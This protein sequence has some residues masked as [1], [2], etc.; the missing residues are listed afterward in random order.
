[1]NSWL[2]RSVFRF[3]DPPSSGSE[4]TRRVPPVKPAKGLRPLIS[5]RNPLA[6]CQSLLPRVAR[7]GPLCGRTQRVRNSRSGPHSGPTAAGVLGLPTAEGFRHSYAAITREEADVAT[8][9]ITVSALLA[10]MVGSVGA[11]DGRAL[12]QAVAKNIGADN[13][14]TLQISGTGWNAAPGQSFS[15]SDDWPKFEVTSY[16]KAIDFGARFSRE[17]VTRRQGNYPPRGGGGTPI[18]RSEEH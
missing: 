6:G 9:L 17:Q 1:M 3:I 18:Q 2:R 4:Y 15:P 10:L 14:T 13:P 11:Q 8:R 5:P 16:T 12:L 7:L